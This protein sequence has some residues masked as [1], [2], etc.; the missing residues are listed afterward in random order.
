MILTPPPMNLW[1][2]LYS[3]GIPYFD[4]DQKLHLREEEIGKRSG[5]ME[6]SDLVIVTS[7]PIKLWNGY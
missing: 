4:T 2:A 3:H 6:F 7:C 5:A 1:N